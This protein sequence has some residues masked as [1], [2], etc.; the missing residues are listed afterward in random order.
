MVKFHKSTKN[1]ECNDKII[2]REILVKNIGLVD[3]CK[4][5]QYVY[6]VKEDIMKLLELN[7]KK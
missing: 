1:I 3:L 4:R 7:N 6:Q 5:V 2:K